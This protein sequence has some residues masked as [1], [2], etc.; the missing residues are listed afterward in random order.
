MVA[1]WPA[2]GTRGRPWP[3]PVDGSCAAS[4]CRSPSGWLIARRWA[5][6]S[7]PDGRNRVGRTIGLALWAGRASRAIRDASLRL[8]RI[9]TVHLL[10]R[11]RVSMARWSWP[12]D[13]GGGA[14]GGPARPGG[15]PVASPGGAARRWRRRRHGP[16]AGFSCWPDSG[17]PVL[18]GEVGAE[19]PAPLDAVE[20]RR[21]AAGLSLGSGMREGVEVLYGLQCRPEVG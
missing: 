14:A 6:S 13:R 19:L 17:T 4:L 9:P 21:C 20:Q 15:R 18:K 12:G 8:R 16:P 7:A 11:S 10:P 5:S 2:R 1:R 3:G